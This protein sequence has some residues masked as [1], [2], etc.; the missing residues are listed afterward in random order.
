MIVA[1]L[2]GLNETSGKV[3][4]ASE[5]TI[6]DV[7]TIASAVYDVANVIQMDETDAN[8]VHYI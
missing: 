8:K 7:R 2:S 1:R 3:R 5:R 6:A 4:L